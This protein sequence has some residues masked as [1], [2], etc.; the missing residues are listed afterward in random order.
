MLCA[1][2]S[3]D[4]SEKACPSSGSHVRNEEHVADNDVSA[5]FGAYAAFYDE[6]YADKDYSAE[7]RALRDVFSLHRVGSGVAVL[8][9]GCGTGGHAI[10]LSQAGYQVTGVDRSPEMVEVARQKALGAGVSPHLVVGDV[11]TVALGET[12]DVVI[13]MFAVVGYM[14]TNEDLAS[15]FATAR[16][17]LECGGLFVFDA[18]FG[19]AVLTQRPEFK[20]KE[21]AL[22]GGG[23]LVRTAIPFLDV[24]TETVRVD[25]RVVRHQG[26]RDVET[27]EESHTMRFMFAQGIAYMLQ[28]AGFEVLELA[29]FGAPGVT[30]T[31]SD[32]NVSWVARAV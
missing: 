20:R 24:V 6:L 12:F 21:V 11:R 25:Y 17:H 23:L 31:E 8:D 1:V 18:W 26:G 4:M 7:V 30:P 19:P 14:L 3:R 29:P 15:M 28:V 32:W 9:L 16:R 10:P 22:A 13:S 27:V 2:C 5:V